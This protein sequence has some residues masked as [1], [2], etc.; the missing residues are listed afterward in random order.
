MGLSWAVG[1]E[2]QAREAEED[3]SNLSS[4]TFLG[5]EVELGKVS[6]HSLLPSLGRLNPSPA[7][8][9]LFLFRTMSVKRIAQRLP[10]LVFPPA[11]ARPSTPFLARAT[12]S[13]TSPPPSDSPSPSPSS[14]SSIPPPAAPTASSST[15][16]ATKPASKAAAPP[17]AA[18]LSKAERAEARKKLAAMPAAPPPKVIQ[19][20]RLGDVGPN[21][22][23]E[24]YHNQLADD[25]LYLTYS[26]RLAIDPDLPVG[27]LTAFE[28][29]PTD[30]YAINRPNP[31]P[32]GRRSTIIPVRKA[33]NHSNVPRLEQIVL[34]TTVREATRQKS[35][36]LG[37][38][39]AMRT[40]SDRKSVV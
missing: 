38:L 2:G 5:R 36:L 39:H 18:K 22:L 24:F 23:R 14:S 9:V 25:M 30:R 12:S 32:K 7:S 8:L 28:Q 35:Q 3:D 37:A 10:K 11:A 33:V 31:R 34:S 13:A 26:H 40:I 16:P 15:P 27:K 1:V 29:N 20:L 6:S 17:K 21:R 4:P 19:D